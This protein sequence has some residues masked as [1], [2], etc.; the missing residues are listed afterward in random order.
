MQEL[1]KK[2]SNLIKSSKLVKEQILFFED[3][4]KAMKQIKKLCNIDEEKLGL[5]LLDDSVSG[6]F[7][8]EIDKM[9][10]VR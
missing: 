2:L 9:F 7:H 3:P 5:V 1:F 4:K 10:H 8:V 6:D